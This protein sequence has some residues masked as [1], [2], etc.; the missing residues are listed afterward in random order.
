MSHLNRSYGLEIAKGNIPGTTYVHKFGEAPDFDTSDLAVTIWDGADDGGLNEMQYNYSSGA[1]IDA[2]SSSD[3][4]DTQDYEIQGLDV[5]WDLTV[6]TITAAGQ[7]LTA[8]DTPLRRVFRIKNKNATD[9]AGTIYVYED[10]DG[11]TNGVPDTLA[12]VRAII[13]PGNNQTLMSIYTVPNGKT[14]YM[15][16]FWF[17]LEGAKKATP[18]DVKLRVKP[19]GGVFKIKFKAD[20]IEDGTSYLYHHHDIPEKIEAKSDIEMRAAIVDAA[21]TGQSVSAGFEL[22]IVDD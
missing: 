9:N 5:N 20:L 14:A 4:G 21:I 3:N 7:T 15:T 11:E 17:S 8:L 19:I 18:V 1:D 13:Q 16:N 6:Q 22:I 10:T 12:D 2:I